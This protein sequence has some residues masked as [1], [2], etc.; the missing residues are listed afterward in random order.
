MDT[1]CLV[2]RNVIKELELKINSPVIIQKEKKKEKQKNETKCFLCSLY[3][4]KQINS[5]QVSYGKS[6]KLPLSIFQ[7]N[8]DKTVQI[9]PDLIL[10]SIHGITNLASRIELQ[11]IKKNKRKS[12]NS[13]GCLTNY[14]LRIYVSNLLQGA[15]V[16]KG[17]IIKFKDLG[18]TF[19]VFSIRPFAFA[20]KIHLNTGVSVSFKLEKKSTLNQ[21]RSQYYKQKETETHSK[22]A[23]NLSNKQ[24][25]VSLNE[26]S[27]QI[28]GYSQQTNRL[29]ELLN[30]AFFSTKQL[31]LTTGILLSG[32]KGIGKKSI[33]KAYSKLSSVPI[34]EL[35]A[36]MIQTRLVG[37][38]EKT[39]R[40]TFNK[41][42]NFNSKVILLIN[43]CENVCQKRKLGSN[44]S[45]RLTSQMISLLD[46]TFKKNEKQKKRNKQKKSK[47]Q[48]KTEPNL[49]FNKQ[50]I[51]IIGIT[52]KKDLIDRSIT[53]PGRIDILIEFN[54]PNINERQQILQICGKQFNSNNPVKEKVTH[55]KVDQDQD[56][57]KNKLNW[58]L[59]AEKTNG[60]VAKD[61]SQLCKYAVLNA[62]R[63]ADSEK[64]PDEKIQVN[65][66]DFLLAI[67]LLVQ[68]GGQSQLKPSKDRIKR[69]T[70]EDIGGL[71]DVKL[72]I[73]QAVEWPIKYPE[74]FKR[75][76][77]E[78][79]KGTSKTTLAKAVA[80]ST[81]CTFLSVSGAEIF[82]KYL[83][84]AERIVRNLF[85][86]A[87]KSHP[88]I[89]FID[90]IESMVGK[91]SLSSSKSS[92]NNVKDRVLSTFLNELDGIEQI[93]GVVVIGST[94]RPDLI[95]EAL[96]RPGR[97]G[98]ILSVPLPD[99]QSR[100]KIFS[101]KTKNMIIHQNVDLDLLSGELTDGFSGA[102]IENL[103]REA[104]LLSLRENINNENV[105]MK[106]FQMALKN[107]N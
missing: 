30:I 7:S 36:N 27:S 29:I 78:Q 16:T 31:G 47:K 62:I 55:E 41:A 68:G 95:D 52:T 10:H 63:R 44:R 69:V 2:G 76:N 33:I 79:L 6:I 83:G 100:R 66:Q 43:N 65:N 101:I 53:R 98:K 71:E 19:Q 5:V 84:E 102:E 70:W 67:N 25:P 56:Q 20:T 77:L 26:M 8:I 104:A 89:I 61:L 51:V 34:I 94:N 1:L 103:C 45:N 93:Q 85:Q 17:C 32:I 99:Q 54:Q 42:F 21:P 38:G 13:L 90:E 50:N 92:S 48:K 3:S 14:Q 87:R 12:I 39:L 75:L 64:I 23:N 91:R 105:Q 46:L 11:L 81:N 59:I 88:T 37:K 73:K 58:K 15:W 80:N 40:D 74:S 82:S 97:F 24:S 49:N 107:K 57:E 106:H 96:L 35:D 28:G 18:L 22:E 60:F 9:L 72:K 4:D 86:Q